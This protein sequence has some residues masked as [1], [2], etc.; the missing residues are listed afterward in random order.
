MLNRYFEIEQHRSSIRREILA[1]VTTF[2]TMAYIL[3]VNPAILSFAGMDFGGVFVA[4]CIAA[5][6]GTGIMGLWARYP[7]ALAP[8]MGLNGFFTYGIVRGMGHP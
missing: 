4:T 7:I 3:F 5:A 1:G 8:G 6:V 2:L